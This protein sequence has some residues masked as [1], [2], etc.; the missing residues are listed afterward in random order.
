MSRS[1]SDTWTP[2]AR[3]RLPRSACHNC[4]R[5]KDCPYSHDRILDRALYQAAL[6][7]KAAAQ[8]LEAEACHLCEVFSGAGSPSLL[9]YANERLE[10]TLAALLR[11]ELETLERLSAL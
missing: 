8:P 2:G 9:L 10:L 4:R 6:Q 3:S 5:R 11:A 7:G 1:V